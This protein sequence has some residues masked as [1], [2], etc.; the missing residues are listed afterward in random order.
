MPTEARHLACLRRARGGEQPSQV[1]WAHGVYRRLSKRLLVWGQWHAVQA[2]HGHG[3][4][5]TSL[6]HQCARPWWRLPT[7]SASTRGSEGKGMVPKL[8]RR[9]GEDA[10]AMGVLSQGPSPIVGGGRS[11]ERAMR[12]V[13]SERPA[14]KTGLVI[15]SH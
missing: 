12:A 3:G 4:R 1:F 8:C 10:G 2:P 13:R 15:G 6:S 9:T 11:R 7:I 5:R 14:E